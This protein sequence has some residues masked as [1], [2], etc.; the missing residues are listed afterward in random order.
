MTQ[1]RHRVIQTETFEERLAGRAKDLRDRAKVM[2]HGVEKDALLKRA[3]QA[4]SGAQIS[5]WLRSPEIR[6]QTGN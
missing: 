1:I 6:A 5:E 3:R 2:P 4:E